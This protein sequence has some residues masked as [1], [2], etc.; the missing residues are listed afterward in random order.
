MADT[1]SYDLVAYDTD[2]KAEVLHWQNLPVNSVAS[3][4]AGTIII[5]GSEHW[6]VVG[7]HSNS[8]ARLKKI[9]VRQTPAEFPSDA[10]MQYVKTSGIG[11]AFTDSESAAL[12]FEGPAQAKKLR[13]RLASQFTN[14]V[15][16]VVEG[17]KGYCLVVRPSQK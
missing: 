4:A 9:D 10:W 17:S 3:Y 8:T 14:Y 2:T 7:V 16:E 6:L 1:E 5:D 15:W 13:D 12:H 11:Y